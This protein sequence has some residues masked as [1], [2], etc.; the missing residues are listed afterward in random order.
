MGYRN[1]KNVEREESEMNFN[2]LGEK[3]IEEVSRVIIGKKEVLEILLIALL[4]EG[5]VLL[6][7]SPGTG[8]TLMATCFARALGGTFHRIQMTPDLLPADI[9]G[10]TVFHPGKIS[11]EIKPGPIFANV[12]LADELNR[13]TPKNQS[14]LLEAMQEKQVT[15]E[16]NTLDLPRPFI[17]FATQLPYGGPG[18]FPFSEV[19]IDRFAFMVRVDFPSPKE[20]EEIIS[21][22]DDLENPKISPQANPEEIMLL[23]E[24]VKK[25]HVS[26][27]VKG[28]IVNLVNNIRKEQYVK[29]P[30][31][32]RASIWLYKGSRTRAL[33]EGRNYVIPDD[34]KVLT[35]YV[36][37][38]RITLSPQIETEEISS[39]E[40]INKTLNSVPV[41]KE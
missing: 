9:I 35:P 29:I 14:A 1:I 31:S 19:Q 37:A 7:G 39:S 4:S 30:P 8:K 28:Y 17:V 26:E 3:L 2:N 32:P 16:G 25:V 20:E 34:V 33:L 5:H 24:E 10:T 27:K 23:V 12:I 22:I 21:K 38:H 13:T 6:E 41:P 15:I 11:F 40:I 36:F 18:T